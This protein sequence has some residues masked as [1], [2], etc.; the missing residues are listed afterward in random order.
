MIFILGFYNP[1]KFQFGSKAKKQKSKKAKKAKRQKGK[2]NIERFTIQQI[3]FKLR[4]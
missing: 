3:K 1:N 2:K 4:S